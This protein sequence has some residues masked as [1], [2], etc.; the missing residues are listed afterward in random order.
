MSHF[1]RAL[2]KELGIQ[3]NISMAFYPQTD[4]LTE[5]TNQWVE[6]YLRL[7]TANQEDWSNWLAVATIVHNNAKNSTT[8]YSPNQLLISLEPDLIPEQSSSGNNHLAEEQSRLLHECRVMA[9]HAL[10]EMANSLGTP[11]T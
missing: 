4:G 1:R 10:N 6:Q 11:E 2:A 3:Q 8:H 5:Q 9:A 7:I